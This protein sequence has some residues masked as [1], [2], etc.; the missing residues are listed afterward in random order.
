M[1]TWW[2]SLANLRLLSPPKSWL[3]AHL[4]GAALLQVQILVTLAS[5]G[6]LGRNVTLCLHVK[7]PNAFSLLIDA[8]KVPS[9][10]LPSKLSGQEP[11]RLGWECG[12]KL[13]GGRLC[14]SSASGPL[15]T[16]HFVLYQT[17]NS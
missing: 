1:T 16:V 2:A 11:S 17:C 12:S 13:A 9:L 4:Q 15:H 5:L 10:S 6:P 8:T 14:V 7:P 3:P